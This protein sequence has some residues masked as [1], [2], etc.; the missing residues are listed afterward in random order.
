MRRA[1]LLLL[2][3]VVAGCADSLADLPI[4]SPTSPAQIAVAPLPVVPIRWG[5]DVNVAMKQ[6]SGWQEG[7]V[8]ELQ[9]AR[10][11][12]ED[13]LHR[14]SDPALLEKQAGNRFQARG[15]PIPASGQKEIIVSYSQELTSARDPYRL[16][17][18]GLPRLGRLDLRVVFDD[19]A[20]TSS[21]SPS[22]RAFELHEADFLPDRDYA[23]PLAGA[24]A[25]RGLRND[26][27][28]VARVR[29]VAESKPDPIR[30]LL[31]LFDTSAS[32]A[33]DLRAQA[34]HLAAILAQLQKQ[35]GGDIPVA[36][37]CFDQELAPIYAGPASGFGKRELDAILERRALGAT[38]L[39][40]ALSSAAAFASKKGKTFHRALLLT[41]GV[42]TAGPTEGNAF[43]AEL[44]SLREAGVERLDVLVAGGIR[45]E[46]LL[47]ALVV[48][49]LPR[50]GL[51]L[52]GDLAPRALAERLGQ[53]TTSRIA[54]R[55]PGA[56][57]SWPAT[58]SGVQPGD[59]VLVYASLPPGAPF[60]IELAGPLGTSKHTVSTLPVERPLLD[61][62]AVKA[63]IE[64]LTRARDDAKDEA[65]ARI[66]QD[67][68]DLSTRNR[69]LSDFTALLVLETDSPSPDRRAPIRTGCRRTTR[70]PIRLNQPKYIAFG[71][72]TVRKR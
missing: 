6:E 53:G 16:Y 58:V 47:R 10:A 50:D 31:V 45:D 15:F 54:V 41:D 51:V 68:I 57:W 63:Q 13:F 69:V 37:A 28:A 3:A 48:G 71:A 9:A 59:D 7:E 39:A 33:L 17:L 26:D 23:L 35:S 5:A 38:D 1:R 52:D 25:D 49:G 20:P 8:V 14:R 19:H 4:P 12:Y 44:A 55:V 65:R 43:K 32:R 46:S 34:D 21:T 42:P 36:V 67:I 66:T 29:P 64:R 18:R 27:L 62:A 60:E 2:L 56:R 70:A 40:F 22:R 24:I 11:A 61:R 72:A 30:D